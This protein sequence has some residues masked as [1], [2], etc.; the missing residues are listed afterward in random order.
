MDMKRLFT[1]LL[2]VLLCA[3]PVFAWENG[4]LTV[5]D[6]GLTGEFTALIP[7][8]V[9]MVNGFRQERGQPPI[10]E[11]DIDLD[12]MYP[13]YTS[14]NYFD[15]EIGS[16][17]EFLR[18]I[19]EQEDYIW[20]LPLE[21]GGENIQ[22]GITRTRPVRDGVEEVLTAEELAALQ[23]RVGKWG[24]TWV[25]FGKNPAANWKTVAQAAAPDAD[26]IVLVNRLD[27]VVALFAVCIKDGT[28]GDV[29]AVTDSVI[30]IN[31]EDAAAIA[32]RSSLRVTSQ[33]IDLRCGERF[34]Y[35]ELQDTIG[36][37]EPDPGLL[38][39]VPRS[40]VGFRLNDR[41]H[42]VSALV[43]IPVLTMAAAAAAAA[44]Y[45]RKK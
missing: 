43:G 36:R 11:A 22:V 25:S 38:Q 27:G 39:I 16:A 23:A 34:S 29:I 19:E 7:E 15:P 26:Q 40:G 33:A 44:W 32:A 18:R 13:Y 20:I 24:C 1:V 30:P 4:F 28:F 14:R 6:A 5:A 42:N 21:I 31:A 9:E 2:A 35:A 8:I 12:A 17:G 41:V 10:G 3:S 37:L 45:R